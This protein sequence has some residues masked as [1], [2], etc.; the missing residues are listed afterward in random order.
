MKLVK[1][2]RGHFVAYLALFFALGGTS[3]A[4]STA[5]GPNT[6]GT[7]Q[8]KKNAVIGSK[9]KNNSLTGADILESSLAKVPSAA[10][11]DSATSATSA[12]TATNATNATNATSATNATNASNLGGHAAS[13]YSP[14]VLQSGTSE[15]GTYMVGGNNTGG[16][17]LIGQ[18]FAFPIPLAAALDSAHV[19]WLNGTTT[20]NCP[21][22]GHAAAGFLC[23]YATAAAT[24]TPDNAHAVNTHA[25]FG[26][27]DPYGFMLAFD[28]GGVNSF[29][30]GSWTVTA[31]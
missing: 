27:A 23:V 18:G 10:K 1:H 20:T 6:V 21:G 24:V 2:M 22:V 12:T 13:F 4:A 15:S 25:G 19:A 28:A 11:A 29:S 26:G 14:A 9:V 8:L 5:L 16:G 3:I 17:Q 7:K 30:Y 31:P